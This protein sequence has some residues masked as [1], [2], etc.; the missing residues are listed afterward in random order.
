MRNRGQKP[1]STLLVEPWSEALSQVKYQ[2]GRDLPV[3]FMLAVYGLLVVAALVL[4]LFLS[5]R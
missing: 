1:P 4:A 5:A 2:R 3:R